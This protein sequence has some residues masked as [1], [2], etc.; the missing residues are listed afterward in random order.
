MMRES[1]IANSPRNRFAALPTDSQPPFVR[2]GGYSSRT[3]F[4]TGFLSKTAYSVGCWAIRSKFRQKSK[5]WQ[6]LK[7]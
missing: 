6:K 7:F 5:F 3:E 2:I 1:W 4:C